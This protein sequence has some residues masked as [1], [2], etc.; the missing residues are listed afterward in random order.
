MI[1]TNSLPKSLE[2]KTLQPNSLQTLLYNQSVWQSTVNLWQFAF[3]GVLITCPAF[4]SILPTTT[5]YDFQLVHGLI[6]C[7]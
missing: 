2:A 7:E 4:P 5:L 6:D 3:Q 1:Q